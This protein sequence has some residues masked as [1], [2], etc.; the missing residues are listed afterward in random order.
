MSVLTNE[1]WN[2][3]EYLKRCHTRVLMKYRDKCYKLNGYYDILENNSA[4]VVTEDQIRAELATREH[5][6]NKKEAKALRKERIKKG[7]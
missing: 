4:C 6:P 5:V 1:V 7:R 3:V 2:P